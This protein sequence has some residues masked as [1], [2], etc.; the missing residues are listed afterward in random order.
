VCWSTGGREDRAATSLQRDRFHSMSA[1]FLLC[2]VVFRACYVTDGSN[3]CANR[4]RLW[5]MARSD[6]LSAAQA[7]RIA[8][9]A[10]GFG[11]PRPTGAVDRRHGRKL[12]DRLGLIQVDS[13]NV[14]TRQQEL[15]LFARLG[16]HRRDLIPSMIQADEL[17][18]YWAHEASLVPV[19][20]HPLLRW[21]MEAARRF[22]TGWGGLV[23]LAQEKPGFVED[24][25]QRVAEFG[26]IA[27]SELAPDRK[28]GGSWWS[29][30][31]EKIALEYLFWCG[32]ITGRRRP[33]S[34]EREYSVTEAVI[35]KRILDLPTPSVEEAHRELLMIAAR[36]HG[37]GT[38]TDLD[39][40]YRL[41]GAQP[42]L[43]ELV[44]EGRLRLVQVEG[45]KQPAY[46]HPEAVVP[47]RVS[48]RALLSPFDALIWERARTERIFGMRYRI[49]I[50][51]PQPKRQYGYYVLPF[52]LGEDLVAR[53]DLKSDRQAGV[54]LVQS[55]WGEPGI[56]ETEVAQELHAE[57]VLMAAWLGLDNG[58]QVERRGDLATALRKVAG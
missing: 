47:R 54:L 44:E 33:N 22:E 21:R 9:G 23:R 56:N 8:L 29:W 32:R 28:K 26:P 4:Y 24:V 1:V 49:E 37:I 46:L 41:K 27:A 42:R 14:L 16:P 34:F 53:V 50:Y 5:P 52:L 45:W 55:V 38:R 57:L 20:Q 43:D 2:V 30:G 11:A 10:Q 51:V 7:R 36:A 31:N 15:P 35:P 6:V 25:Y 12:F 3:L 19:E 58:V 17:F 48:A 39:D 13:V 40:Y 18:E